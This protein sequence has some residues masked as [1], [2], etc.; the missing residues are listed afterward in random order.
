MSWEPIEE[1]E[2]KRNLLQAAGRQVG[3]ATAKVA[4]GLVGGVGNLSNLA[5]VGLEKLN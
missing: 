2:P 1:E 5:S 3:R 4:E